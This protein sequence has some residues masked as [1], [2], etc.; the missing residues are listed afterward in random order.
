[1]HSALNPLT[2]SAQ[3][4]SLGVLI[5][6]AEHMHTKRKADDRG[7]FLC[8]GLKPICPQSSAM[9]ILLG[10]STQLHSL[11]P[12]QVV[13]ELQSS[14]AAWLDHTSLRLDCSCR[15][16]LQREM[17][18]KRM[19]QRVKQRQTFSLKL[20]PLTCKCMRALVTRW[21]IVHLLLLFS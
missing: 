8:I 1:M 9:E 12:N 3:K 10:L 16:E 2:Y 11:Q 4:S 5:P 14:Y 6:H 21:G 18:G 15:L 7:M 20:S 19:R 17:G 13:S